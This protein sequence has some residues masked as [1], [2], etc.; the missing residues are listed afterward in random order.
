[1]SSLKFLS[2]S[3]CNT[4]PARS[5]EFCVPPQVFQLLDGQC[6]HIGRH[7]YRIYT[8]IPVKDIIKMSE[9]TYKHSFIFE[10]NDTV[11][12]DI[13][14]LHSMQSCPHVSCVTALK[15]EMIT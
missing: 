10:S 7:L 5:L 4:Q 1:M 2:V 3:F 14:S 15:C 11:K 9:M 8:K 13:W 12:F 6:G